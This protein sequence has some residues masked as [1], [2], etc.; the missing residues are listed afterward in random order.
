MKNFLS[1][2][3]QKDKQRKKM[4][5]A[6][7]NDIRS[8]MSK[9]IAQAKKLDGPNAPENAKAMMTLKKLIQMLPQLSAQWF[10]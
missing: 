10:K 2:A 6:F 4:G 3:D 5:I 7:A 9:Y 8:L 1:E